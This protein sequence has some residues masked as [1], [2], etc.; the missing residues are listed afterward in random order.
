MKWQYQGSGEWSPHSCLALSC[1]VS[2]PPPPG[3]CGSL[4]FC[5]LATVGPSEHSADQHQAVSQ[6]P[7][8]VEGPNS[9]FL[10]HCGK[11]CVCVYVALRIAMPCFHTPSPFAG[12]YLW[13]VFNTSEPVHGTCAS[14]SPYLECTPKLVSE[15]RYTQHA[16]FIAPHGQ[17]AHGLQAC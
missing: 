4:R 15:V 6:G 1:W 12:P 9:V 3:W 10:M 16:V 5:G 11:V 14:P 17:F 13:H 7:A 2:L 8:R